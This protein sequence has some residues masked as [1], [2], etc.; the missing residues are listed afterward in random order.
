MAEEFSQSISLNELAQRHHFTSSYISKRIKQDTEYSFIEILNAIRLMNAAKFLAEGDKVNR[1]CE[2]AGFN[3]QR[4]FSQ[5]FKRVF[6]CSPSEYKKQ[7]NMVSGIRFH[8]ILEH[9]AKSKWSRE[10]GEDDTAL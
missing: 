5:I 9:I 7:E 4:Y 1:A 6:H 3:D 2:K 8:E 10:D